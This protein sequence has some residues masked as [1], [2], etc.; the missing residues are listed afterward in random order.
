MV[1]TLSIAGRIPGLSFGGFSADLRPQRR[2]L[3]STMSRTRTGDEANASRQSQRPPWDNGL[4]NRDV[5]IG[6]PVLRSTSPSRS[7]PS[8]MPMT[9]H[10]PL[11]TPTFSWLSHPQS[12]NN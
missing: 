3:V 6:R 1:V 12:V 5:L 2:P 8:T 10:S 11:P 4:L 7:L 9:V